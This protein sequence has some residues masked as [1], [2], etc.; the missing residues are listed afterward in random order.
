[1]LLK[2]VVV[3]VGGVIEA[4]AGKTSLPELLGCQRPAH[5]QGPAT[6]ASAATPPHPTRSTS[7]SR[8]TDRLCCTSHLPILYFNPSCL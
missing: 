8:P 1:M 3:W 5:P 4:L 6:N 7:F 2:H